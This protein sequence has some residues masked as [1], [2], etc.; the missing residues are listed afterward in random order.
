MFFS[1][2]NI[3]STIA[4]LCGPW[5]ADMSRSDRR[6]GENSIF[7]QLS[8]E[9]SD[10]C[11]RGE[12]EEKEAKSFLRLSKSDEKKSIWRRTRSN[13]TTDGTDP[14][15]IFLEQ[16]LESDEEEDPNTSKRLIS[17]ADVVRVSSVDQGLFSSGWMIGLFG[18]EPDER[19][20]EELFFR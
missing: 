10:L 14:T 16:M 3:S 7:S 20:K 2:E 13:E 11:A 4:N 5:R 12:R 17:W 9:M 15:G 1:A 8:D 6:W 19:I 18:R